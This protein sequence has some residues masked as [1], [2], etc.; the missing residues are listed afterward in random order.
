M[1]RAL[2]VKVVGIADDD[3]EPFGTFRFLRAMAMAG[4]EACDPRPLA[5]VLD[6]SQLDYK[7][8]DSMA[9]VLTAGAR[10]AGTGFP[11]AVVVSH[12]NEAGLTSLVAQELAANPKEWLFP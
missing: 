8:G 2:V 6:L 12:R 1:L 10:W 9:G 5:L 3:R 7:W 11:T 4:L